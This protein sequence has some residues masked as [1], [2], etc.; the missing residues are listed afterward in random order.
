[1]PI[2]LKYLCVCVKEE[3]LTVNPNEN[4]IAFEITNYNDEFEEIVKNNVFL[5]KSDVKHLIKELSLLVETP[6][7]IYT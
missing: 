4:E 2:Q 7:K 3:F 6:D 5:S 1:M